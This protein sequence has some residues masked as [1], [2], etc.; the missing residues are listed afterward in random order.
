VCVNTVSKKIR[1]L[2]PNTYTFF[3]HTKKDNLRQHTY[4]IHQGLGQNC[5][6]ERGKNRAR[7]GGEASATAGAREDGGESSCGHAASREE[8]PGQRWMGRKRWR[9]LQGAAAPGTEEGGPLNPFVGGAPPVAVTRVPL[10]GL[11]GRERSRLDEKGQ[12]WSIGA[13]SGDGLGR[14][15][16]NR[17]G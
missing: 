12:R 14:R 6:A 17:V 5:K 8:G 3:A 1:D 11:A 9:Y 2:Q 16:G 4:R 10:L 7:G 13:G 15:L